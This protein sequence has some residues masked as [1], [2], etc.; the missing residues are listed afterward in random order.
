MADSVSRGPPTPP[1]IQRRLQLTRL[2]HFGLPFLF[3]I[4]I[5]ALF[6]LLGEH[7]TTAQADGAGVALHMR[8]PDRAHYRQPLTVRLSVRNETPSRMDTVTV[9]LD[10]AFM[11][12]FSEVSMSAPLD[13]AYV[14]R[15]TA[16]APGETRVITAM[17]SGEDA[18]RH[19]GTVS[20][21]SPLG[22]VSTRV[23]TFIFP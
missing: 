1:T 21:T 6:G 16:L 22:T 14:A 2:Q 7:F 15:L 8:Y 5:L 20:V 13:G 9:V 10:S 17:V 23:A 3:L 12:G 11:A 18:G 4:P 19:A